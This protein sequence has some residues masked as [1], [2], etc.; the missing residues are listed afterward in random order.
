MMMFVRLFEV[1]TVFTE[2]RSTDVVYAV[3]F[4]SSFR[5]RTRK[6]PESS[7]GGTGTRQFLH[8]FAHIIA[9][10]ISRPPRMYPSVRKFESQHNLEILESILMPILH[11]AKCIL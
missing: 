10:R 8:I 7:P 5:S 2:Y 3:A 9:T 4:C 11:N 1:R 6:A